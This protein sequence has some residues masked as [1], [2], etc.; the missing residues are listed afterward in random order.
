M[1]KSKTIKVDDLAI[2]VLTSKNNRVTIGYRRINNM[3][4]VAV[5]YCAPA[6]KW[7]RKTGTEIV[8]ARLAIAASGDDCTGVFSVPNF[9][10]E[11]D[12]MI[13]AILEN[14][15]GGFYADAAS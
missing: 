6:D 10:N 12:D 14:M 4:Q 3:V 5:S 9:H 1:F 15:F 2:T 11:S 13:S 7:K 8:A